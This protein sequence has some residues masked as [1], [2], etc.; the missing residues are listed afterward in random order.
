MGKTLDYD[1]S[2]D[3]Y[4]QPIAEFSMGHEAFGLW[5]SEELKADSHKIQALL[6]A[7]DALEKHTSFEAVFMAWGMELTLTREEAEIA[8]LQD[9]F[10]E[11]PEDTDLSEDNSH[12]HCG[13][14][15][16]KAA[17]LSWR[18]FIEAPTGR[19]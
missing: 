19:S 13:L 17:L 18:S 16:F 3:E 4:D 11:L 5:F 14:A 9:T 8:P 12:A 7:V 10:D 15:D 6:K 1:F 2:F